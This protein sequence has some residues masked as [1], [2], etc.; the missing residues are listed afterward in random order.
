MKAYRAIVKHSERYYEDV[1]IYALTFK[2]F[3][4]R[5]YFHLCISNDVKS[6]SCHL[7]F[8][9]LT[10]PIPIPKKARLCISTH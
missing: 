7:L 9:P 10:I 1:I 4:A 2:D 8:G 6:V 5:L 3:K